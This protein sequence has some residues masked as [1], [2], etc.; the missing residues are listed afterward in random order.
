M[1]FLNSLKELKNLDQDRLMQIGST[2]ALVVAILLFGY[3]SY[4]NLV[5]QRKIKDLLP[6]VKEVP[7]ISSTL[8]ATILESKEFKDLKTNGDFPLTSSSYG[9]GN[10]FL[11]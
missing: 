1:N 10:P 2:A 5:S 6:Q 3:L 4:A 8:N 9:G 7:I 11:K